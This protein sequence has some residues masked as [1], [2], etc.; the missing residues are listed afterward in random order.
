VPAQLLTA[1]SP[2]MRRAPICLVATILVPGWLSQARAQPAPDD[3]SLTGPWARYDANHDGTVTL[4]EMDA[5]LKA[6]F[7]ALDRDHDGQLNGSEISA[8]NDRRAEADPSAT[9]LFDWKGSGFVD[10]AEFSAPMH[11]LFAQMDR[12]KDGVLTQH[13]ADSAPADGGGA[14]PAQSQGRSGRHRR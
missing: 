13:E 12:N 2:R 10:F 7:N 14:A 8:E 1:K 11:T 9:L 5:V 4:A 6:D 3:Q